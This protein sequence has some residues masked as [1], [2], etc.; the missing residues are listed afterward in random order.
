MKRKSILVLTSLLIVLLIS[1][2][3]KSESTINSLTEDDIKTLE[4]ATKQYRDA[5]AI[6]DWET[7]TKLYTDNAIRM[8]PKGPTIQGRNQILKEFRARPSKIIEYDQKIAEVEGIGDFAF[9]RGVFSYTADT[10]GKI[11]SGTG[12]Y[13]AIYRRQKEGQ[14]LIDRDIFNFD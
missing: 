14:W 9:V 1:A 3:Q 5:E 10:D 13:I 7:V 6:N 8:L 4:I 2:C 12:K 11:S